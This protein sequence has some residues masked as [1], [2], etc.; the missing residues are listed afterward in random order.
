MYE[1]STEDLLQEFAKM[2]EVV[3]V[4]KRINAESKLTYD[5]RTVDP[6]T[7]RHSIRTE[8]IDDIYVNYEPPLQKK[9]RLRFIENCTNRDSS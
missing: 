1:C 9:K 4:I 6:Y 3:D 7:H 5:V 8:S 2:E